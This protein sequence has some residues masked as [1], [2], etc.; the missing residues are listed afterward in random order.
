SNTSFRAFNDESNASA[1]TDDEVGSGVV[2]FSGTIGN[3]ST[4]VFS[5]T[6]VTSSA[7]TGTFTLDEAGVGFTT[8]DGTLQTKNY[9]LISGSIT[10]TQWDGI[11]G[12]CKGTFSGVANEVISQE[13]V[14]ITN[15]KFDC[16]IIED[17][18]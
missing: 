5:I 2:T 7:R 9:G 13:F 3:N 11:G 8:T 10:I 16:R 18:D 15:G 4:H 1:Y 6:I 17:A 14:T 12:R